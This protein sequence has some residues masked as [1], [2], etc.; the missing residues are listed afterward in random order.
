MEKLYHITDT[1]ALKAARQVGHLT[2][3]SLKS[4]GFVHCSFSS[5]LLWVANNFFTGQSDLLVLV[6]DPVKLEAE[7]RVEEVPEANAWFPHLYGPINLSS[8]QQEIPLAPGN[9]GA[10]HWTFSPAEK[11]SV[12]QL[13]AA[14]NWYDHPEGPKFVETHRDSHRTCG[15]WLF[16]PGAISAFHQVQNSDELWLIHAGRLTVH[17][18]DPMGVHRT[19]T[20]GTDLSAG[21]VPILEVPRTFWQAAELP[22]GTP[23]AFGSNVCAPSFTFDNLHLPERRLL[24][25]TWP[26]HTSVIQRLTHDGSEHE[27]MNGIP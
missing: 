20:L 8:V 27:G 11:D 6:L 26:A 9:D 4:E 15:H 18:I 25:D 19:H 14:H 21:E 17:T 3:P 16:A 2:P 10:F 24:M 5:Q 22:F 12:Q 1:E 13:L 23:Y 7:L